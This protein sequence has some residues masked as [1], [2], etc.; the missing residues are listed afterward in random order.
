MED[1]QLSLTADLINDIL[2]GSP[3]PQAHSADFINLPKK[4]P[5]CTIANGRP[6]TNLAT[7]W[8]L[9]AGLP[10][11]HYQPR[12][13]AN[14]TLPPHESGM[15]PHCSSVEL[16]RVLHDVWWYGWRQL[17]EAR[18]LSDDARHAYGSLSHDTEYG[19]LTA[20][21]I[22]DGDARVLQRHDRTLKV[23]MAGTDRRAR[24]STCLGAGRGQGC[25]V[26]CMK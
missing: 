2:R 24:S 1:S 6:L 8:K 26:S 25:P 16:L 7:V 19:V 17:L 5:H 20:A 14:G 9:T 13:V 23:H 4:A 10:K 21:G 11:N 12:L 18:V 22:S 3:V 15:Y